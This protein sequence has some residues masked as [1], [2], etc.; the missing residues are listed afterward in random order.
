[1]KH[2][3]VRQSIG[4]SAS[5]IADAGSG[6]RSSRSSRPRGSMEG[7]VEAMRRD[8]RIEIKGVEQ[9]GGRTMAVAF[10][11]SYQGRYP[12]VV[13]TVTNA[14]AALYVEENVRLREQQ[15]AGTAA[16]LRGQLA[17]T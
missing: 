16:F 1:M 2:A 8:I 14:L 12:Q 17:E 10:V 3:G 11:L 4:C 5:G 6:S 7:A 15:A 13:A 9:P